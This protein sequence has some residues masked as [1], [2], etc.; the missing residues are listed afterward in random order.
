VEP[1]TSLQK[2]IEVR[3]AASGTEV[4]VPSSHNEP[5]LFR[6]N[7]RMGTHDDGTGGIAISVFHRAACILQT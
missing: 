6:W 4:T 1:L 7:I 3:M 2:E 5:F